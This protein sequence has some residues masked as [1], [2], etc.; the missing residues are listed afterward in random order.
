MDVKA[1]QRQDRK[2]WRELDARKGKEGES[3]GEAAE[4]HARRDWNEKKTWVARVRNEVERTGENWTQG[5]G[6]KGEGSGGKREGNK[7][8]ET[9]GGA[10]IEPWKE[11]VRIRT[12]SGD[13]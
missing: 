5:K 13:G 2:N 4:I 1:E 12:G 10:S 6:R 8:G 7:G 9:R 11:M 3:E